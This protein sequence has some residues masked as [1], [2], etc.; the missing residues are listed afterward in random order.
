MNS[1]YGGYGGQYGY[2]NRDYAR[3]DV[4]FR[5]NVDY[6]GQVTNLRIGRN[7]AYRR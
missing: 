2:Q 3:G 1:G 6:R 5:C 4:S 7:M